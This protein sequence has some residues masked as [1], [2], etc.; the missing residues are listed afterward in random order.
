MAVSIMGVSIPFLAP[1][2]RT[3]EMRGARRRYISPPAGHALEILGHAIEYLTD[4]YVHEGEIFS[5]HDPRLEAVQLLMA[6]NRK[7]YFSCPEVPTF[8]DRLSAWLHW[9]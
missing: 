9:R 5:P 1:A 8:G 4:E 7:I 3:A 6:C 2:V